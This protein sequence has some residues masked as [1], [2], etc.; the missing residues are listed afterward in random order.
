MKVLHLPSPEKIPQRAIAGVCSDTRAVK[1]DDLFVAVV[2]NQQDSHQLIPA[3]VHAGAT[4]VVGQKPKDPRWNLP[5]N[6]LYLQV[7]QSQKALGLLAAA[8]YDQPSVALKVIGVTGTS[9]KT[10]TTYAIESIFKEADWPCAVLGTIQYRFG[11]QVLPASH[12]TPDAPEIQKLFA[13]F[14]KRKIPAA[15]M[16]V[17][18]HALKQFRV[19]GVAFDGAVFTNLSAEHLDYHP[20]MEDYFESKSRLFIEELCESQLLGKRPFCVINEDDPAGKTLLQKVQAAQY[21]QGTPRCLTYSLKNP[22]ASL[23]CEKL[24]IGSEGLH[25]KVRGLQNFSLQSP[26]FGEFNAS[27]ILCAATVG[28][29]LGL[30]SEK[31]SAG[32][33]KLLS[34]PGRLER[35]PNPHGIFVLVDYAHKPD[36]LE[37]VLK[38]LRPMVMKG[39]R[40]I[41]VF[42]CGGDRDRTKRPVMGRIASSLSDRTYVTSD[43]PRTEN[44]EQIIQEIT[45][46]IPDL[47]QVQIQQD[48]RLAIQQ[49]IQEAASG[50]F[51]LIA[52]KGHEDYQIL[53]APQ[54]PGG[55]Q[56]IP[57]DDRLVAQEALQ[58]R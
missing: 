12:T 6:V 31:V 32:I 29:G 16:E 8:Y 28:I 25:L 53:P 11:E 30:P 5:E 51:V 22:Q 33:A 45:G 24:N 9:G 38:A 56:K 42:G 34:V 49:A 15:V 10:T 2:G 47:S 27:N 21:P 46:G 35:V 14:R 4:V 23:N 26:L 17:S 39:K 54:N 19:R 58:K 7:D 40:L 36:A 57:F 48:R 44:P 18:S 52:G 55:V 1:K 37:K 50:D 20:T 13:D 3:A 43:N 41:T